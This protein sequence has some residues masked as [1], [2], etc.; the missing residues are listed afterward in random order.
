VELRDAA[1]ADVLGSLT[2]GVEPASR[3]RLD[4]RSDLP[5]GALPTVLRAADQGGFDSVIGRRRV[6][7]PP[8]SGA[9]R[10]APHRASA[11]RGL[12]ASHDLVVQR[13]GLLQARDAEISV[14]EPGVLRNDGVLGGDLVLEGSYVQGPAGT[15]RADIVQ[16]P[17]PGAGRALDP[18]AAARFPRRALRAKP[19]LPA[20][21]PIVVTGNATLDGRVELQFGNGVAPRR[22]RRSSC[23]TSEARSR[24]LRRGL[25]QGSCRGATPSSRASPAG[26]S[27][28]PL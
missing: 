4:L 27:R 8:S 26:S 25:D 16:V 22:A 13:L 11:P 1:R 23:S 12:R 9:G 10:R 24:G 15:R 7:R 3:A 17:G 20:F 5:A 6:P 2:V 18:L 14:Q 21:A 28:S 19:A